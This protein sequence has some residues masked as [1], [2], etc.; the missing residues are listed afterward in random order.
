[1]EVKATSRGLLDLSKGDLCRTHYLADEVP[2]FHSD[3][4]LRFRPVDFQYAKVF[5]E[6]AIAHSVRVFFFAGFLCLVHGA[7][8]DV[9]ERVG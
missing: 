9:E 4:G 5:P 7:G 6:V 3:A 2:N 1:M 8:G